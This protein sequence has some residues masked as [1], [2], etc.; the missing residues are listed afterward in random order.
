MKKYEPKDLQICDD[1][2]VWI[3]RHREMYLDANVTPAALVDALTSEVIALGIESIGSFSR[4]GWHIVGAR[5]DWM[6]EGRCWA[7]DEDTFHR[8][9]ALPELGQNC[10]RAEVL[11]AA[12]AQDV[13]TI[14]ASRMTAISGRCDI[15]QTLEREMTAR[16]WVRLVAFRMGE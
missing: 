8:I 6:R 7:S 16:Q 5:Q 2:L 14:L 15:Q 4:D 10:M 12:F 13:V 11:V 3:R 1:A 9:I